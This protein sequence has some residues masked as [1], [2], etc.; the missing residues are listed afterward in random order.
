[1]GLASPHSTKLSNKSSVFPGVGPVHHLALLSNR[2]V[3][4]QISGQDTGQDSSIL[5]DA[6]GR[7]ERD[8]AGGSLGEFCC[9]CYKINNMR[10]HHVCTVRKK[11][12]LIFTNVSFKI[13]PI[14]LT[15]GKWPHAFISSHL[16]SLRTIINNYSQLL[17]F[18]LYESPFF[19]VFFINQMLN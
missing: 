12:Q 6:S 13:Y 19:N 18:S 10:N 14:T 2:S 4:M 5:L 8:G 15:W 3:G 1:M 7:M 11:Q 17:Y 9:C 16:N